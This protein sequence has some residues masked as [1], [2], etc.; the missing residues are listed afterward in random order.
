MILYIKNI[1]LHFPLILFNS[2]ISPQDISSNSVERL[3]KINKCTNSFSN[4]LEKM[5]LKNECQKT[6]QSVVAYFPRKPHL[7][8]IINNVSSGHFYSITVSE[9]VCS[10]TVLHF[11]Y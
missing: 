11:L 9:D 10:R 3:V 2:I 6:M 5:S 1:V 4:V 8:S 7:F